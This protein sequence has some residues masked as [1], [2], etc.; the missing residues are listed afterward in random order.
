MRQLDPPE[1]VRLRGS[2]RAAWSHDLRLESAEAVAPPAAA[3]GI[4]IGGSLGQDKAE[5]HGS[6]A[7]RR[8]SSTGSPRSGRGT[9]WG[10]ATSTT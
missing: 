10:S 9:C 8:T 2:C 4:A 6:S 3:G 1:Q 5:M 7:G